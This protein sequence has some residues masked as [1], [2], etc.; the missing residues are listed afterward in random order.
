RR[1]LYFAGALY[2]LSLLSKSMAISLFGVV[3]LMDWA[4]GRRDW[5]AMVLEKWPMVLGVILALIVY[6]VLYHPKA[7]TFIGGFGEG[8]AAPPGS[9]AEVPGAYQQVLIANFRYLFF[10]LHTIFPV[11]LALVYP[12][13]FLLAF[14]GALIHGLFVLTAAI[15][16]LP[17]VLKKYRTLLITGLLFFTMTISPILIEEGPGTNFGSDRYTYVPS[18]GVLMLISV[19]ALTRLKGLVYKTFTYGHLVLAIIAIAFAA[20][21]FGQAIKWDKSLTLYDQAV[22]N[23][24]ENWVALHYR[25]GELEDTDVAAAL[26][27]Y[28][29]SLR[30]NPRR[31]QTWFSRGTLYLNLRRY[32]EAMADFTRTLELNPS[33]WK[34]WVNRGNCK[35]D[36]GR[37]QE[38][39]EDYNV[40]LAKRPRF[41][42]ALNNRG[43]AYLNLGQ[44]DQALADFNKVLR[45]D[46]NYAKGYINRAAVYF[47]NQVRQYENAIADY[48]R[49]LQIE[50]DNWQ[51]HY[52]RGLSLQR[53]QRYDAALQSV[54]TAIQLRPN[55][56]LYYY[57]QAQIL[58][59]MGRL[60]ESVQA[61]QT[62]RS[63]GYDVPAQYLSQ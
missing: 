9:I 13:E 42:K 15:W 17:F 20:G 11:R 44:M 25:G 6:G 60:A 7:K 31:A 8:A 63:L 12:R 50:P 35:R 51:A 16:A 57:S 22:N 49:C 28:S 19:F 4:S 36:L 56:G 43:V 26:A 61:A 2:I 59:S 40:V 27:D 32:E 5:K 37:N 46:P 23:Y 55:T 34:A 30:I 14:P 3:F 47:N 1:Y 24:P 62:A 53:L 41:I 48:D 58:R 38:A 39:I 18:L 33:F 21:T 10:L 45:I 54:N 52:F 29:E